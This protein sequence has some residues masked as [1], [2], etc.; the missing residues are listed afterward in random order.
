MKRMHTTHFGTLIDKR[1]GQRGN[2]LASVSSTSY[3]FGGKV[4]SLHW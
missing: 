3:A 1:N 2:A 4:T